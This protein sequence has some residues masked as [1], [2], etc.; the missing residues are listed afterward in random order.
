MARTMKEFR[1]SALSLCL[2][3]AG[4]GLAA[5]TQAQT[6]NPSS[7]STAQSVPSSDKSF[8]EKAAIGGLA[9]VEMGKLAQEKAGS[10]QVKQFGQRMVDDHSKANDELKQVATAK[11]L[12]LP[13]DLDAKHKSKLD[14]LQK[15]SGAQFDRAYMDDMVA[16]HKQDVGEFQKEAKSGK[17]SDIKGFAS[18]TL[19][20]LQEHLKMAESTHAAVKSGGKSAMGSSKSSGG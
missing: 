11:G 15:L 4:L 10:E 3:L 1:L 14:K 17:D 16:D 8:A 9:E 18:K 19:P 6:A 20:T 12:T 2:G 5:G 7:G 13:T